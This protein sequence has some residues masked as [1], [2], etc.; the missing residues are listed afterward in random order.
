MLQEGS[1]FA[2]YQSLYKEME[3]RKRAESD[4]DA[5]GGSKTA[6]LG[7][8]L[9]STSYAGATRTDEDG[10]DRGRRGP[11]PVCFEGSQCSGWQVS[12]LAGHMQWRTLRSSPLVRVACR[13]HPH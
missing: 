12:A 4:G 13:R 11:V 10:V 1:Q 6:R 7:E 3:K 8:E 2:G 9:I 5:R